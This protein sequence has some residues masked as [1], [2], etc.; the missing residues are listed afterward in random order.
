MTKTHK[1]CQRQGK[2][3]SANQRLNPSPHHICDSLKSSEHHWQAHLCQQS[4]VKYSIHT[5]TK[6]KGGWQ[7][8]KRIQSTLTLHINPATT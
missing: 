3:N 1:K 7:N 4:K 5:P 2:D 6:K 8:K